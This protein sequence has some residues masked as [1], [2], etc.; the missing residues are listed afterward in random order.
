MDAMRARLDSLDL[1]EFGL[2][3]TEPTIPAAL[4]R[5]RLDVF[6]DRARARGL[7]HVVVYADREHFANLAYLT[8]YDPRFEEALLIVRLDG[9]SGRPK[10]LVGNE[11]LGYARISPVYDDLEI[12]TFQSFSLLGQPRGES[13]PLA[14]ILS[15]AGITRGSRVGT[16]GWKYFSPGEGDRDGLRLEIPSYLA[17]A[18]REACGSGAAVRNANSLLMDAETGLRAVNEADQIARFD[19]VGTHASQAVRNVLFG[20]QP[21]MTELDAA[22]LMRLNGL[23]LSCHVMLSAGER[24]WMGMGSPTMRPLCEGDAFTV[25]CGLWGELTSRAGF[26][27][28]DPAGLPAGIRDYVERLV[29]PYF[30]AVA[31]WYELVGIGVRGGELHRAVHDRIGGPFF[32][33]TLNPGHLVHLD[34][35]VHSP[36]FAGSAAMLSSGMALQVDVIPATGGPFFTTNIEDGIALADDGLRAEIADRFPEAWGRIEA[37]RRFMADGLGIRLKPEVLP[38]SNLPAYLP[39]CVLDPRRAM[40]IAHLETGRSP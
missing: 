30:E 12:V 1:P 28:A 14:D 2:P 36:I 35:W 13:A 19:F 33:V 25:A 9:G 7:T 4:H 17:D 34:E 3:V 37:R 26:L 20:V 11:G 15:S 38:L 8:G 40:R 5:R 10:L 32:G 22:T 16:A 6:G 29:A 27:V 18:L 21:G 23:P 31:A 24:A 39:P